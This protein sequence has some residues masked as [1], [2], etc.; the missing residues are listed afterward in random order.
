MRVLADSPALRAEAS[1]NLAVL[2]AALS[3]VYFKKRAV[4]SRLAAKVMAGIVIATLD[5]AI[6]AWA[7]QAARRSLQFHVTRAFAVLDTLSARPARS[8]S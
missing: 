1:Q 7:A 8:S 5:A 6:T 3:A 4:P 2:Q